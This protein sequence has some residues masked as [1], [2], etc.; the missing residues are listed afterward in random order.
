MSKTDKENL[1]QL[2]GVAHVLVEALEKLFDE[3]GQMKPDI[4]KQ[5]IDELKA[6]ARD[7]ACRAN[8][9]QNTIGGIAE[10]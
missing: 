9:I 4:T 5:Q 1:K 7:T 6:L 2:Y 10:K 8:A 3:K